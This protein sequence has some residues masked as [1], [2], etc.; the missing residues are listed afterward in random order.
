MSKTRAQSCLILGLEDPGPGC[1]R[2]EI[3]GLFDRAFYKIKLK[4]HLPCSSVLC[5]HLDTGIAHCCITGECR[6]WGHGSLWQWKND[7]PLIG[8]P[9][10]TVIHNETEPSKMVMPPTAKARWPDSRSSEA[11]L[12]K[13]VCCGQAPVTQHSCRDMGDGGRRTGGKLM[14]HLARNTQLCSR[15]SKT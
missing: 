3:P 8:Q 12:K 9:N 7:A 14:G 2:S 4:E 10:I 15:S 11:V 6:S 1:I 13:K 5:G